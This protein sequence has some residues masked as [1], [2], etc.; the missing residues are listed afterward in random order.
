MQV[1]VS[2]RL[3]MPTA[4]ALRA[5]GTGRADVG[6]TATVRK[7]GASGW[8]AVEGGFLK[9]GDPDGLPLRNVALWSVGAGR[10]LAGDVY[11]LGSLAGNSSV[12]PEYSAPIEAAF[13]VGM[14]VG[15]RL[16]LSVLPS[17]GFSN[18]S[19]S[20]AVTAGFSTDVWRR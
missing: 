3:K 18:S 8:V 20:F 13:G 17:V 1:V 10:R 5:L 2:G 6:A 9:V 4:S 19:P 15:E 11:L 7:L 12:L 16:T 14:R